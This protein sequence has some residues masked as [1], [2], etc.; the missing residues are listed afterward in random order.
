[1][2]LVSVKIVNFISDFKSNRAI[3]IRDFS[4]IVIWPGSH[5]PTTYLPSS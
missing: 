4:K 2:M 1:M 5:Y 3:I